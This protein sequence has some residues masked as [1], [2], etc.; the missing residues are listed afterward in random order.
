[1]FTIRNKN[2]ILELLQDKNKSLVKIVM[3]N[4]LKQDGLTQQIV[5]TASQN[6]VSIENRPL[7]KMPKDRSGKDREVI[8]GLIE[9]NN[10]TTL[11]MWMKKLD[12]NDIEPFFLLLNR[13]KYA[14]NIGTIIRTAFAAGVNGIIFQGDENDFLNDETIHFSLGAILRIP[15]I[16]MGIFQALTA[17]EKYAIPVYSI[18]MHGKNYFEE[19]FTGPAAFIPGAENRGVSDTVQD[20]C[21]KH[22]SIPMQEG[23]DSMNVAI[24]TGIVIYEKVRQE[25][26]ICT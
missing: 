4:N 26:Q 9:P 19:D 11:N 13:I 25:Q 15:L 20:R 12:K 23:I 22:I 16:K 7:Q 14:N 18:Q 17:L 5:H 8:A 2:A 10:F 1:M 3:V 6:K 24:S 21:D